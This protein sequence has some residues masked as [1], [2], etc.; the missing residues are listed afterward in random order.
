MNNLNYGLKNGRH[1][2]FISERE[3]AK[4]PV[5]A[6]IGYYENI[7]WNHTYNSKTKEV[8]VGKLV[9]IF[10]MKTG[11]E[12]RALH[13]KNWLLKEIREIPTVTAN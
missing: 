13:L 3:I 11:E 12:Q 2:P 10:T 6:Q 1:T 7:L 5:D 4:M 8:I 9:D